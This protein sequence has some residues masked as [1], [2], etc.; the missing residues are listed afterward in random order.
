[1]QPNTD[2]EFSKRLREACD[3]SIDVPGHG[4]GQQVDLANKMNVSQ[5]S[6]RKWL[7]VGTRPRPK[8]M[9]KLASLLNVDEA[10]L[11]LGVDPGLSETEK[12]EW[13]ENSTGAEYA[14]F[15]MLSL[16]GYHCAFANEKGVDFHAVGHGQHLSVSV[17]MAKDTLPGEYVA[18]LPIKNKDGLR[19]VAVPGARKPDFI[20]IP[21]DI[22]LKDA[23]VA[24]DKVAVSFN[25]VKGGYEI[26]GELV[27]PITNWIL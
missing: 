24:G 3:R 25:K 14:V 12:R 13:R 16:S 4:E 7:H 5:E 23:T 19:M 20:V 15:G 21:E 8:T 18:Y 10:W 6:A 27:K 26:V 11:A 1:M 9:S 2:L 22:D 17:S